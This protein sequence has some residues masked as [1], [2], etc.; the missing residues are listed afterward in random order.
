MD[1]GLSATVFLSYQEEHA[2]A[3]PHFQRTAREVIVALMHV[4]VT[5][6]VEELSSCIAW[7]A[8]LLRFR[9]A[10]SQNLAKQEQI[11]KQCAQ[12]D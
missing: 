9:D 12:M 10:L 1:A 7:C 4:E 8:T 5:D 2:E 6:L 11:G 3:M